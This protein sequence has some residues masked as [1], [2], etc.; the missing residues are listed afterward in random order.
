MAISLALSGAGH[1][2]AEVYGRHV[3][4]HPEDLRFVAVA[5]PRIERREDFAAEHGIPAE[6]AFASGEDLFR[7]AAKIADAVIIAAPEE[8]H[9]PQA[10]AALALGYDVL[11]EKPLAARVEDCR[12]LAEEA[13]KNH[14]LLMVCHPLRHAPFFL[15][16][17]QLLAEG[18]I[19]RLISIQYNA[20]V[21]FRQMAH[22]YVRGERN[23]AGKTGPLVLSEGAQDLD[24]LLWL[25]GADC[26]RVSSFG[27]LMFFRPENAPTGAA[28]RCLENCAIEQAC[29][30][31]ARRIYLGADTSWP[32]ST[33]SRDQS[34]EARTEALRTGPF[35]RCIYGCENAVLDHQVVAAEFAN[36]VTA[37]L[38]LCGLTHERSRAIKIMGST[39]EIEGHLEKNEIA[40]YTYADDLVTVMR[41][42]RPETGRAGG[43]EGLMR[44]FAEA[45]RLHQRGR[46]PDPAWVGLQ[47]HLMALA[48]EEARLQ[49][50]VVEMKE[51]R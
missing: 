29:P 28:E 6:K 37:A 21:G 31:S 14:R 26:V 22:F 1:R 15:T 42:P 45:V 49:N 36:G 25:A 13:A 4:R 11:L 44:A 19:G 18:R 51:F 32:I 3:F 7:A 17:K 46:E 8:L 27:S 24:L 30:F 9:V 5:E 38:N 43:D 34:I 41:P 48:A 20:N 12:A 39:G 33:I 23:G 10:K 16:I 50:R 40:L 35:G 2:G 47:S